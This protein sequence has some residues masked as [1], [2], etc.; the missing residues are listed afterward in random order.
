MFLI[1][2]EKAEI[3][4]FKELLKIVNKDNLEL[5][6]LITVENNFIK[7]G[8]VDKLSLLRYGEV[9]LG[10]NLKDFVDNDIEEVKD[11]IISIVNSE[12]EVPVMVAC[13]CSIIE[14]LNS[15]YVNEES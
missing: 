5:K 6:D 10:S 1:N 8:N 3:K 14:V 2:I 11:R 7:R 13:I 9:F 4:F 12:L 15:K